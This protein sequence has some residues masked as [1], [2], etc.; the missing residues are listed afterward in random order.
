MA[1][2]VAIGA[3]GSAASSGVTSLNCPAAGKHSVPNSTTHQAPAMRWLKRPLKNSLMVID[4][5]RATY[6]NSDQ[7]NF[8]LFLCQHSYVV[9][10][11]ANR[12]QP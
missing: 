2:V 7:V 3:V 10:G 6:K 9:G 12:H 8:D 4:L 1:R 5:S 11:C